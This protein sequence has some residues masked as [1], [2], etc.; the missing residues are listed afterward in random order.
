MRSSMVGAAMILVL[1]SAA[2]AF[3][4]GLT[5]KGSADGANHGSVEVDFGLDDANAIADRE[6]TW[7]PPS[8]RENLLGAFSGTPQMTIEFGH[9]TRAGMGAPTKVSSLVMNIG[10]PGAL[11][12]AVLVITV[13]GDRQWSIPLNDLS[14][15][16]PLSRRGGMIGL[17]GATLADSTASDGPVRP[18]LLDAVEKARSLTVEV[19]GAH[20]RV[21]SARTYDLSDHAERNALFP[22][23]WA[24]AVIAARHPDDCDDGSSTE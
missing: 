7:N 6:T 13:D 20:G 14:T 12:G 11:S 21:G 15:H 5:C 2:P 8:G 10:S 23:A 16:T 18:D 22:K 4:D 17:G 24:V 1:V 3:A 9:A 19:M